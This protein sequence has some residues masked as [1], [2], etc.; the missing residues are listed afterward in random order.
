[1]DRN[2]PRGLILSLQPV[3]PLAG[4]VDRN[5]NGLGKLTVGKLSLPSRGAWIEILTPPPNLPLNMMSLPSRGA[6]IEIKPNCLALLMVAVAP[7]AGSVDRNIVV[8][9]L[10]GLS[11]VAPLAGSVDRNDE[12]NPDKMKEVKVAPLAGSVDRN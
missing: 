9:S 11:P 12:I 1:M 4:S 7:L 5:S 8:T 2:K 3:A 10:R 6:W